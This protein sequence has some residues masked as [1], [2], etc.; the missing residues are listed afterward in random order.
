MIACGGAPARVRTLAGRKALPR[1][2]ITT[3]SRSLTEAL[4]LDRERAAGWTL[5]RV[6]QNSLWDVE[7]GATSLAPSQVAMAQAMLERL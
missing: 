6:L 4:G 5:G 7:G 2:G 3:C 1:K